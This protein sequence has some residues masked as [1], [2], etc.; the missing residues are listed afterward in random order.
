MVPSSPSW[1]TRGSTDRVG[2]SSGAHV[3]PG[4]CRR[5][6]RPG[7]RANVA[8]LGDLTGH[9]TSS[10]SGYLDALRQRRAVFVAAGATASDHGHPSPA[11]VDL[12]PREAEALFGRIVARTE[13]PGEA[14]IFRAQMLVEM[15]AMSL[16]DG[17]TLQ[18]HA[19]SWRGH[20]PTVAAR[21]GPD[22][23]ADIPRAADYVRDLKP[24][25]DR[26]G[27]EPRL[28]VIAYT[29][30]ETTYSRELAS[31]ATRGPS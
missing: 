14:E 27:N 26:F 12:S 9:D 2:G 1:R 28:T 24:L 7:F 3:P 25:L 20:N 22:K 15:A 13:H 17:L 23:G 16:D 19:G 4:R 6:Q 8:T 31:T 18:I 30:D 5:P 10:W 21:F 29:L 11:T